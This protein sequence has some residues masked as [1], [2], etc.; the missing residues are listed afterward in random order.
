MDPPPGD[1]ADPSATAYSTTNTQV[2]SVD[3]ADY[4]KNDGNTV[5]VLSP[6]GLRVIDAWPAPETHVVAQIAIPGEPRRLFLGD[7]R[8][9]VYSRI[10]AVSG[11]GASRT[12]PSD[13][14]CTYGYGCRFTSDGG[15]SLVIVYDVS[16]PAQPKELIRYEMSGGYVASAAK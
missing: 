5:Y 1:T 14:G 7:Q 11:V 15:H 13:Q 9:V 12:N 3:E 10:Q 16:T 6:D 4:V 8:L 2:A